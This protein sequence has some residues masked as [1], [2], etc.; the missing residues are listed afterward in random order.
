MRFKGHSNA[1]YLFDF[2]DNGS[3]TGTTNRIVMYSDSSTGIV[4][5]WL[6]GSAR[7]TDSQKR[8]NSWNH[9]ALVRSGSTTTLYVN[10]ISQ[11]T[12]SDSTN[13]SGA[14]VVIGQRQEQQV[15][16]GMVLF[17]MLVSLKEPH[18]IPLTSHHQKEHSQM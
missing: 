8:I 17:L 15:K 1:P 3:D 10:G 12:Y 11:G 2:R 14:P 4:R 13:Y 18:F 6:N 16:V 5:F 9:Y 7:I